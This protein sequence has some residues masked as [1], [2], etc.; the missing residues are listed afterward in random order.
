MRVVSH[1]LPQERPGFDNP[2]AGH[3]M[4]QKCKV[5]KIIWICFLCPSPAIVCLLKLDAELLVHTGGQ[6]AGL[7]R[8]WILLAKADAIS[9]RCDKRPCQ[10]SDSACVRIPIYAEHL[11]NPQ[12]T[13]T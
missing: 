6:L 5:P 8:Q 3:E 1:R 13:C 7:S 12:P 2:Y 10:Q 11:G 4:V 9:N